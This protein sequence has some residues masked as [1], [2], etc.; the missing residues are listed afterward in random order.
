MVRIPHE[1]AVRSTHQTTLLIIHQEM[2]HDQ[3]P[4]HTV[5]ML[6]GY[7]ENCSTSYL[8]FSKQ[9]APT[10]TTTW[11]WYQCGCRR[12]WSPVRG[13]R[14]RAENYRASPY[15]QYLTDQSH[16]HATWT[17][18]YVTPQ[19]SPASYSISDKGKDSKGWVY[20]LYHYCTQIY[21]WPLESHS[22]S[23]TLQYDQAENI[24]SVQPATPTR[25]ITSFSVWMEA[26]NLYLAVRVSLNPLC[27]PLLIVYQRIITTANSQHPLH[28]WISYHV[29]FRTKAAGDSSL[30]WDIR[31]LDLWAWMFSGNLRSVC[32]LAMY[33]LR[34]YQPFPQ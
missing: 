3:R 15:N 4:P 23:L 11:G 33:I 30:R 7:Q 21:I 25:R 18:C 19:A 8:L 9:G 27:A 26:W 34:W 32:L 17:I 1:E 14:P 24:F 28:A 6:Q 10:P 12:W 31:Y 5:K 13:F 20:W 29:K 16:H 2:V 22:Q